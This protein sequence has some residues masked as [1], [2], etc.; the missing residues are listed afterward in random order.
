VGGGYT[1]LW[2][3]YY[4]AKAEPNRRGGVGHMIGAVDEV[5]RVSASEGIAADIDKAGELL[6]A[7]NAAQ[8]RRPVPVGLAH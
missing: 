3:A 8:A 7:V 6:V 2:T 5:I 4:L 1:G